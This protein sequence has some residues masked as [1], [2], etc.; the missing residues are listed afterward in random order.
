MIKRAILY[1]CKQINPLGILNTYIFVFVFSSDLYNGNTALKSC[2]IVYHHINTTGLTA[3]KLSKAVEDSSTPTSN[4]N[5]LR[6]G[7]YDSF[8][9][10]KDKI[11]A[12]GT[13]A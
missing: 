5:E 3:E 10:V 1:T 9:I 11:E 12:S 13:V 4:A 7:K 8:V 6:F 2:F